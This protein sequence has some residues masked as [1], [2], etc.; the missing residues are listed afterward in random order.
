MGSTD[1]L[2]EEDERARSDANTVTDAGAVVA[3]DADADTGG[4]AGDELGLGAGLRD[5]DAAADCELVGPRAVSDDDALLATEGFLDG[6]STSEAR[7]N[8]SVA[9]AGS[10]RLCQCRSVSWT[11]KRSSPSVTTAASK[12]G[13]KRRIARR[14]VK[15]STNAI[16]RGDRKVVAT[17]AAVSAGHGRGKC[18]TANFAPRESVYELPPG[19]RPDT[20]APLAALWRL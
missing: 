19:R 6:S 7:R 2:P 11:T 8:D 3:A 16:E 5:R 20:L 17:E 4:A 10:G 1:G 13:R 9:A 14:P 15:G 12:R 18:Q